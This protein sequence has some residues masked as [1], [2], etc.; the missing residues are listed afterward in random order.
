MHVESKEELIALLKLVGY[1]EDAGAPPGWRLAMVDRF[2][3]QRPKIFLLWVNGCKIHG[4]NKFL[5]FTEVW[6]YIG[7]LNV[8]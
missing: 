4:V 2:A 8:K 5:T 1:A 7:A 3:Q 6:E